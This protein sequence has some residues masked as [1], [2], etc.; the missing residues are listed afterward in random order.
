MS[1]R[2]PGLTTTFA[3]ILVSS[4]CQ[5]S[6]GG[7]T[8]AQ[9]PNNPTPTPAPAPTD[10]TTTPTPAPVD[11]SP[12]LKVPRA[13]PGAA[14]PTPTTTANPNLSPT[15]AGGVVLMKGTNDF[16]SGTETPDSFKGAIY[17]IPAASPK[18]PDVAA[19]QPAGFLYSRTFD[20]GPRNFDKGFPGVDTRFEWF[21]IR[22]TGTFNVAAAGD[23]K[24]NVLSDDGA[25]VSVDG[26]KVLDNDGQHAPKSANATVKLTAGKHTLQ[27][28]YF[29]GPRYQVAL[30]LWVTPPGGQE[31]LFSASF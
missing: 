3:L 23:Y 19:M 18:F 17:F 5:V 31:K 9:N 27:L 30:Q 29:Q 12:G 25:I 20:I 2:Y 11:T 14:T 1:M 21:A 13:L 10:P 16:G 28:D 4:G 26:S 22:Y 7:G 15:P 24:L 6:M 8:G